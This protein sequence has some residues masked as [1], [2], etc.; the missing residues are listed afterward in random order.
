MYFIVINKYIC[1]VKANINYSCVNGHEQYVHV[2]VLTYLK[3][4]DF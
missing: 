3:G 1:V 4:N 2:S